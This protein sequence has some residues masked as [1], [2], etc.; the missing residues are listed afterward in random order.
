MKFVKN[1]F[2]K[3]LFTITI[4]SIVSLS[5]ATNKPNTVTFNKRTNSND[6][7]NN[8]SFLSGCLPSNHKSF[9]R[10]IFFI[11]ACVFYHPFAK[12]IIDTYSLRR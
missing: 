1:I 8:S 12:L 5:I 4:M 9:K 7:G 3:F 10:Y 11:D 6:W 2:Q